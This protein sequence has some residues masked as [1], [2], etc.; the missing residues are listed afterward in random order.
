M[1]KPACGL[2]LGE[3]RDTARLHAAQQLLARNISVAE[4]CSRPAFNDPNYFSRWFR[5]QT[6]CTPT[7]WRTGQ[8]SW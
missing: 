8:A 6:G 4:V 1:L 7:A 3:L 2:T 5:A